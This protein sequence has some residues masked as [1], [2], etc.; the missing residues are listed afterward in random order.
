LQNP[1]SVRS[2]HPQ[3]ACKPWLFVCLFAFSPSRS[4][5]YSSAGRKQNGRA[6]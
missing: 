5:A 4:E 1:G 3:V 2:V 6:S